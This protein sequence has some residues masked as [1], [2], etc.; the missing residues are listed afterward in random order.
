MCEAVTEI[1]VV[2]S[3]SCS[4]QMLVLDMPRH[5]CRARPAGSLGSPDCSSYPR[6]AYRPVA[7]R[8]PT[9]ATQTLELVQFPVTANYCRMQPSDMKAAMEHRHVAPRSK[10]SN[11]SPA[12]R[13]LWSLSS[14]G[15]GYCALAAIAVQVLPMPIRSMAKLLPLRDRYSE[16][17]SARVLHAASKLRRGHDGFETTP[18][19]RDLHFRCRPWSSG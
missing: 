2:R 14:G 15:I 17:K 16:S 3:P 10:D 12:R 8:R 19:Q 5:S 18:G 6:N 1:V 13:E 11:S 4:V 9:I 7:S